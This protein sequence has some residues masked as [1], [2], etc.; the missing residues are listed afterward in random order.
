MITS[1]D[2]ISDVAVTIEMY[3]KGATG[4]CVFSSFFLAF[5]AFASAL[6]VRSDDGDRSRN[7]RGLLQLFNLLILYEV[8]KS[9]YAGYCM[10]ELQ[11]IRILEACFESAPQALIQLY[12]AMNYIHNWS[13][14]PLM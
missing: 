6:Y 1:S 7:I 9:V 10:Y 11:E 5:H 3:G 2:L 4:P 12:F 8:Y 14:D 13:T